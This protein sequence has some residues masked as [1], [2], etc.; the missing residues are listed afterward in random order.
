MAMSIRVTRPEVWYAKLRAVTLYLDGAPV[1]RVRAGE[2]VVLHGSGRAQLLQARLDWGRSP[3][4]RITDDDRH[5]TEV[6]LS[7]GSLGRALVTTFL[8]PR[9]LIELTVR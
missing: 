5:D 8:R 2:T 7:F 4:V 3:A 1:G 9:S 6:V